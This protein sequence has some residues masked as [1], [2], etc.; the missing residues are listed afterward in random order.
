[1]LKKSTC[2]DCGYP[3]SLTHSEQLFYQHHFG[4]LPKRCKRCRQIQ[5][6]IRADPY[7]GFEEVFANYMPTKPRRNRVHYAPHLVGGFK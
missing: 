4:S 3:F 6:K 1:M 7:Y 2:K 5:H